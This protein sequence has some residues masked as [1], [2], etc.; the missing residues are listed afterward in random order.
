MQDRRRVRRIAMYRCAKILINGALRDCVV[1]DMSTLGVRLALVSTAYMPDRISLT[2]D[3]G[4]TL[5]DC[6]VAWRSEREMGVEFA[7][8]SFRAAA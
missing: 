4:H 2:F 7:A 1:R 8:A 6:R 5:R 3:N